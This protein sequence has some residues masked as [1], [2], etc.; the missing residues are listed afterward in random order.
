MSL[1]NEIK[2][3]QD[4]NLRGENEHA[5]NTLMPSVKGTIDSPILSPQFRHY[6]QVS[7][8][9]ISN[10]SWL[11]YAINFDAQSHCITIY[12]QNTEQLTGTT[13]KVQMCFRFPSYVYCTTSVQGVEYRDAIRLGYGMSDQGKGWFDIYQVAAEVINFARKLRDMMGRNVAY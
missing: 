7:D 10:A 3:L 13:H 5:P 6:C 2:R 1:R 9:L 8:V 4:F 11:S 12:W